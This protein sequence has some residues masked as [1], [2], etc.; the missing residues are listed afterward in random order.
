MFNHIFIDFIGLTGDPGFPQHGHL[1][2]FLS[3][4]STC[5]METKPAPQTCTLTGLIAGETCC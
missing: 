1:W 2:E 5:G 4:D 3:E